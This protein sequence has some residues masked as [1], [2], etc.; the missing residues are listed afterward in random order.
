MKY[1]AGTLGS[2]IKSYS[3][4][5]SELMVGGSLTDAQSSFC[6]AI[7]EAIAETQNTW[8]DSA[9]VTGIQVNGG[10][11]APLGPLTGGMGVGAPGSIVGTISGTGSNAT[12]K[13]PTSAMASLTPA[14]RSYVKSIGDGFETIFNQLLTTSTIS[15]ILVSGGFC[16]CQIILGASVPGTYSGGLGILTSLTSGLKGTALTS[17]NLYSEILSRLDS[18]V[19]A[20]GNPTPSLNASLRAICSA[21]E[22]H[23]DAWLDSTSINNLLVGGGL[24]IPYGPLVGSLGLG[25]KFI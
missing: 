8:Q 15:N 25:G 4:Q 22:E 3:E 9:T 12:S 10:I 5:T 16:T 7:G 20:V 24:S 6:L 23:H 14:L 17:G 11:C 1:D 21:I 2:L 19:L 13:F 18:N